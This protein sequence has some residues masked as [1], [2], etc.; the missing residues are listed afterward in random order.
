MIT[1]QQV[2]R[3]PPRDRAD[4]SEGVK[5]RLAGYRR[6]REKEG[7]ATGGS[8]WASWMGQGDLLWGM[9]DG[10][11]EKARSGVRF[12]GILHVACQEDGRVRHPSRNRLRPLAVTPKESPRQIPQQ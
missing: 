8:R 6:G 11:G 7:P 4:G 1:S 12:G 9:R 5:E 10:P 2:L 3:P